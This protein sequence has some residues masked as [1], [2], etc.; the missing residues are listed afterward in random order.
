[1]IAAAITVM[2]SLVSIV[3][4][5]VAPTAVP[6]QDVAAAGLAIAG[7]L[8]WVLLQVSAVS[9]HTR[10]AGSGSAAESRLREEDLIVS[11]IKRMRFID[12]DA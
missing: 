5:V 6:I 4:V 8:R 11:S 2:K 3:A 10:W 12:A 1:M 7:L 9:L